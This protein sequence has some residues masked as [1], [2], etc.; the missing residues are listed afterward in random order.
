MSDWYRTLIELVGVDANDHIEG[1]PDIDSFNMWD[2]VTGKNT[3]S[4]RTTIP[5]ATPTPD[6][7]FD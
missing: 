1:Y 5:L 2:L 6:K 7:I 3:T 4:P